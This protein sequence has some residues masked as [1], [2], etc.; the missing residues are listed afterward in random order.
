[1]KEKAHENALKEKTADSALSE[2]AP[3]RT[4]IAP[5]DFLELNGK[6]PD[7]TYYFVNKYQLEK[8]GGADRRGW[9]PLNESTAQGES[10]GHEMGH[11]GGSSF[12]VGDL[13]AA[14]MPKEY[15]DKRR[16]A[17]IAQKRALAARF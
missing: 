9:Q 10:L 15:A 8:Y 6:R 17:L 3:W 5:P 1:M 13:V 14:F 4:S 2:K 16:E 12:V 7:R 11:N